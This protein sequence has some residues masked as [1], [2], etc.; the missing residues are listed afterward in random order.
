MAQPHLATADADRV[1]E[2]V[3]SPRELKLIRGGSSLQ[4]KL[5]LALGDLA[6][7]GGADKILTCNGG[8]VLATFPD[9]GPAKDFCRAAELLFL[10]ET[11]G[12]TVTTALTPYTDDTFAEDRKRLIFSKL[13]YN[14]RSVRR[15]AFQAAH[16]WFAICGACGLYPAVEEESN[17]LLC[18]ACRKRRENS[19]RDAD[20][21]RDLGALGKLS[22]P[23]NYL[24]IVYIDIDR[25]G[26]FLGK[27]IKTKEDCETWST[28]IDEAV[29]QSV[30]GACQSLK[31]GGGF[32]PYEILLAGGD[33]ALVALP[34]SYVF[35]FLAAFRLR[36]QEYRR[37]RDLPAYS[38]GLVIAHSHFPIAEFVSLAEDLLRSA[39]SVHDT[40]SIHYAVLTA[41]LADRLSVRG[42]QSADGFRR[43]GN[44]YR[45][46]RFLQLS[47]Q[48]REL[49][50]MEA[51]ASKIRDLY[52][53]SH[54]PQL[55]AE[56]EYAHLLTRL[57]E[58]H[59]A[60]L[61]I[62]LGGSLWCEENGL[63][64]TVA[65]DLAELWDFIHV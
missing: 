18:A 64:F 50:R 56:V 54:Q 63:P 58:R 48:L 32:A 65:A 2:Y 10:K 53:I 4:R 28:A 30:G 60:A 24:A 42:N 15:P 55:H 26:R 31:P 41:S 7:E 22:N 44:P 6:S 20:A 21:P 46:T 3:F 9:E 43:T 5:N 27:Q 1:H 25:L 17:G 45:L 33:D 62:S 52:R 38:I 36:F 23:E 61:R 39:K 34:A 51:P 59:A 19:G 11:H 35:D 29:R 14:K 49:K 47:T 12:A 57:E 37:K 16:P 40:D 13:E 8:T